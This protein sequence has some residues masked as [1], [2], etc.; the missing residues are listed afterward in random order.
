MAAPALDMRS[1]PISALYQRPDPCQL[2]PQRKQNLRF[3][4][5]LALAHSPVKAVCATVWQAAWALQVPRQERRQGAA[6]G[7]Q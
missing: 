3:R 7:Q 1:M 2:M 6:I 4:R 5:A